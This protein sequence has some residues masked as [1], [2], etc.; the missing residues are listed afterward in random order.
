MPDWLHVTVCLRPFDIT[1]PSV[2]W[3]VHLS[4]PR[5]TFS[6]EDYGNRSTLKILISQ[7]G[8]PVVRFCILSFP[9]N[10]NKLNR[11]RWSRVLYERT[12]VVSV[13]CWSIFLKGDCSRWSGRVFRPR[14]RLQSFYFTAGKSCGGGTWDFSAMFSQLSLGGLMMSWSHIC[15]FWLA[16]GCLSQGGGWWGGGGGGPVRPPESFPM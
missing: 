13:D 12:R 6:L 2:S 16:L 5:T 4:T 10:E 1:F 8:H 11:C 15:F 3:S 7:E 9:K 14:A